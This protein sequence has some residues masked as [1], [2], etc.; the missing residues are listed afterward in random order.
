MDST[1]LNHK[2]KVNKDLEHG[3]IVLA[4]LSFILAP[5]LLPVLLTYSTV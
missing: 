2:K 4:W 3:I 1:Q 5:I